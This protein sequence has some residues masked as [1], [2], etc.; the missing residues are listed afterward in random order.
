MAR[1]NLGGGWAGAD[2]GSSIARRPVASLRRL[3]ACRVDDVG[4]LLHVRIQ[5]G[6]ECGGC[7]SLDAGPL[8]DAIWPL[9]RNKDAGSMMRLAV[10]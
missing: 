5:E 8:I 6:F 7:P 10:P 2:A 9:D 4:P 3:K 1:G